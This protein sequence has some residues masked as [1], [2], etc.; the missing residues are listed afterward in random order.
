MAGSAE[1]WLNARRRRVYPWLFL[2]AYVVLGAVWVGLA[3]HGLDSRGKP[4]G[5]DF[6]T[7][8]SA[9]HLALQGQPTAAYDPEAIFQAHQRG[10]PGTEGHYLWHYPPTFFLV[11]LP[12]ALLPYFPAWALFFSISL[13]GWMAVMIRVVPGA[14]LAALAW[15]GTFLNLWQG[16]NGLLT[17]ALLALGLHRLGQGRKLSAG[18]CLGLLAIKPHLALLVPLALAVAREGRAFLAAAVTALGF[19]LVSVLALGP[20]TLTAFLADL[21]R[22]QALVD[23][24]AL[25]W[26]KMPSLLVFIRLLGGGA[27]LATLIQAAGVISAVAAVTWIWSRPATDPDTRA[28]VLA[29]ATP[30]AL[31]YLFDYDLGLAAVAAAFLVR[32]G[33][34]RGWHPGE[35]AVAML[36]WLAPL[37]AAPVAQATHLHVTTLVLIALLVV[38]LRW[39]EPAAG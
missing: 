16:Q 33:L 39:R 12:A 27:D 22:A 28:A 36:A 26:I 5:T 30:L 34:R 10:V 21:P 20:E 18:V 37:V 14:T 7:F 35:R 32:R 9:S 2:V 13:A 23:S 6:I 1:Y 31:P 15:P 25:P 3:Q 29:S 19:L 8:W 11:I 24:G 38:S 4:L 17:A